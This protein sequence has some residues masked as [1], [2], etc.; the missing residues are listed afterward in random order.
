MSPLTCHSLSQG[1][2]A[3]TP[4]QPPGCSSPGDARRD[5]GS[6]CR[7]SRALK[8]ERSPGIPAQPLPAALTPGMHIL[9]Q[10]GTLLSVLVGVS[11]RKKQKQRQRVPWEA[12]I[13][14]EGNKSH[15]GSLFAVLKESTQAPHPDF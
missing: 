7:H 1:D 3:T 14:P 12:K 13:P 2:A 5:S 11:W 15:P 4:L 10:A 6:L 8:G 9:G